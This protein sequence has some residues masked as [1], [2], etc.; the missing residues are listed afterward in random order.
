M[1]PLSR[2]PAPAFVAV[3]MG[4]LWDVDRLQVEM[5]EV[6]KRPAASP[7]QGD[8]LVTMPFAFLNT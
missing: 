6:C 5:M 4:T 7:H 3:L 1:S 2:R 8:H